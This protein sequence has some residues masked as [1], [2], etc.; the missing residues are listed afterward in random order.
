MKFNYDDVSKGNLSQAREGG[1]FI[2]LIGEIMYGYS[3]SLGLNSNNGTKKISML[4]GLRLE[5]VLN[6]KALVVEGDSQIL[7]EGL[8]KILNE[9]HP[10]RVSK[11]WILSFGYSNIATIVRGILSIVPR[12]VRRKGNVVVDYLA[13]V[14]VLKK[15]RINK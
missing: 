12:H 4:L 7:T 8:K 3:I 2:D 15:C 14:V 6:Y 13:N 10:K 5:K 9:T 11:N 1:I